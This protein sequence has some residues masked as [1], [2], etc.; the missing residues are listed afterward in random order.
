[1]NTTGEVAQTINIGNNATAASTSTVVLG[2]TI[3]TSPVTIQAGTS[4]VLVKPANGATAF[5]I[6]NALGTSNLFVADT[7]STRIG[8]GTASPE[9]RF[10]VQGGLVKVG[11]GVNN[12]LTGAGEL[13]VQNNI[14]VDGNSALGDGASDTVSITGATTISNGG[15]NITTL[16]IN[17]TGTGPSLVVNAGN[18]GIGTTNPNFLFHLR[19]AQPFITVSDTDEGAGNQNWRIR[20]G[21]S[22]GTAGD[23]SIHTLTDDFVT[24]TSKFT[25]KRDGNVGIGITAPSSLLQLGSNAGTAASGIKFG[26][27][28]DT[29]LYRTSAGYLKTDTALIVGGVNGF[30]LLDDTGTNTGGIRLGASQDTNLYRSAANVLTTDDSFRIAN[31]QKIY[32]RNAAG[33]ANLRTFDVDTG[34]NINVGRDD[35]ILGI[36]IFGDVQFYDDA[37]SPTLVASIDPNGVYKGGSLERQTSGT[38]SVGTTSSTTAITVGYTSM[39]G[40]LTLGQSTAGETINIGNGNVATGNTNTINIGATATSTGKDVITIGSTVAASTLTLQGGNTASAISIQSAAS[41]TIS[42]GSS[43]VANT[44]QIG[45]TTGEVAQTI[46]IGNNA[47]AASTSTVVL[48]ST[49][50]TSATTIQ[51]G[52]GDIL[53]S[54]TN[55]AIGTSAVAANG[56]LTIGTD[57]TAAT[58][59]IYL[60]TDVNLYRGATARLDTEGDILTRATDGTSQ[61]VKVGAIG[62]SSEAGIRFGVNSGSGG[63]TNLYRG[64]A[65]T[66]KT[67]D[68][69]VVAKELDVGSST[70]G[71]VQG[72]IQFSSDQLATGSPASGKYYA[73]AGSSLV[74]SNLFVFQNTVTQAVSAIDIRGYVDNPTVSGAI[75]VGSRYGIRLEAPVLA[76][77]SAV[78]TNYP[79]YIADQ[80]GGGGTNYG[81][82][83]AAGGLQNTINWAGDTNLYRSAADTLKTDDNFVVG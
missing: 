60:G 9:S 74:S 62:P 64:V 54:A 3:G 35:S 47:T 8:I 28:G 42:L 12:A 53:L 66:L 31:D 72:R 61:G 32:F 70:P 4:G 52:T 78:T 79:I 67:D 18:V 23:F 48:G 22:D 5:Q 21:Q 46:N 82:Y 11:A 68:S 26:S 19:G 20:T 7:A 16:Q 75:T 45:N 6:Q 25:I 38:L 69:L 58:G 50:G 14:E 76:G 57:T 43:G 63:D 13:Y 24:E 59:G 37:A 81:L 83:F 55:T 10:N 34:N 73:I 41:G 15:G 29:N 30:L 39:T 71:T 65:D 80:T 56:V 51:G 36:Q 33:S 40:T 2:S 27:T 49:I 17:N 1:G 44:I 77:G